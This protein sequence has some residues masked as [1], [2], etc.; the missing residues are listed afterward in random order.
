MGMECMIM[1][2]CGDVMVWKPSSKTPLTAIAIQKIVNE[3]MTP[4]GW[5]Y[6]VST[7]RV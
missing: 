3:V 7:C 4:L 1:A 5:I 2:V 6:T